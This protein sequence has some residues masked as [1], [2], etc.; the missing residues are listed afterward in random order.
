MSRKKARM[1]LKNQRDAL[2]NTYGATK[3]TNIEDSYY[4]DHYIA[5]CKMRLGN[6]YFVTESCYTTG[7]GFSSNVGFTKSDNEMEYMNFDYTVSFKKNK[8]CD[9]KNWIAYLQNI[10][11]TDPGLDKHQKVLIE[12]SLQQMREN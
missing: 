11:D 4:G 6:H 3:A 10:V 7:E 1:L 8:G 9:R 5:S 2:W 12:N